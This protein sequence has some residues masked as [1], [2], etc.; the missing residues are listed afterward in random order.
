[1]KKFAKLAAYYQPPPCDMQAKLEFEEKLAA[2]KVLMAEIDENAQSYKDF[3][4]GIDE[5]PEYRLIEDNWK[6]V[7][8]RTLTFGT[9]HVY[10]GSEHKPGSPRFGYIR[11]D[12]VYRCISA[13]IPVAEIISIVRKIETVINNANGTEFPPN[14][15]LLLS[16]MGSDEIKSQFWEDIKKAE[17]ERHSRETGRARPSIEWLREKTAE[18]PN[19]AEIREREM[20]EEE[21]EQEKKRI[22][23][24]GNTNLARY[25]R[26]FRSMRKFVQFRGKGGRPK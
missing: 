3:I 20:T 19:I 16:I 2:L 12:R 22:N 23:L 25:V 9:T 21:R 15:D 5:D 8:L 14:F 18:M 17:L 10:Y 11:A 26:T 13:G 4:N 24:S 7:P 6:P 1:M